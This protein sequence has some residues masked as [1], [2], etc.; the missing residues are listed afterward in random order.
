M[1]LTI[2]FVKIKKFEWNTSRAFVID[3]LVAKNRI[4]IKSNVSFSGKPIAVVQYNAW[5]GGG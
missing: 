3:R 2:D 5:K 4:D 1:I